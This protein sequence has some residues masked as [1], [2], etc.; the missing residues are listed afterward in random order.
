MLSSAYLRP[1]A[2]VLKGS[3]PAPH[4]K[5]RSTTMMTR[6]QFIQ[7]LRSASMDIQGSEICCTLVDELL[8]RTEDFEPKQRRLI[9]IEL[10]TRL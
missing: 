1:A 9:A 4:A 10:A 2:G 7:A 5:E 6:E 3:L 8:Y